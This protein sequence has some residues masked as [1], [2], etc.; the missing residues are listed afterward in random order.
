MARDDRL[1]TLIQ[2]LRDGR[3][4]RAADLADRLGV[5]TRTVW[6]DMALLAATGLPIEGERGVG[7]ILRGPITLPPLILTPAEMDALHKGLTLA[8]Q[9]SDAGVARA[10]RALAGKIATVLPPPE[11][12]DPQDI[13]V[14]EGAAGPRV[15]A[16]L[17]L[18][19]RAISARQRVAISYIDLSGLESHRDIRPLALDL[20]GRIW[21]LGAYCEARG[22][23]RSFRLDRVV[24]VQP[25]A[26]SFPHEPGRELAD[27][28]AR[29][30]QEAVVTPLPETRNSD[31]AGS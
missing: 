1:T 9:D 19:R 2:I 6:R 26:E 27:L 13:F 20:T 31:P 11:N 8:A 28:R 23:F 4:H 12:A 29:M 30:A 21:T 15:A 16:H 7:Y 10:A 22:D 25:T 18:L 17:P 5:S 3:L 14:F 24:A